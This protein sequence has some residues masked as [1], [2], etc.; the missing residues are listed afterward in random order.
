MSKLLKPRTNSLVC[1]HLH[2]EAQPYAHPGTLVNYLVMLARLLLV[3]ARKEIL[4]INPTLPQ[5]V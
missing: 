2:G 5:P 3:F 1:D 4:F